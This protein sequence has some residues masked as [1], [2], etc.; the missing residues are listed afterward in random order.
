MADATIGYQCKDEIEIAVDIDQIWIKAVH[1]GID[2]SGLLDGSHMT[3]LQKLEEEHK[4][5]TR[6]TRMRDPYANCCIWMYKRLD[7]VSL[8]DLP[9]LWRHANKLES[10]REEKKPHANSPFAVAFSPGERP[11]AFHFYKNSFLE[12]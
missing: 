7:H 10:E 1:F 9:L 5:L 12:A 4:Q 11:N 8:H 3:D 6:S 2:V